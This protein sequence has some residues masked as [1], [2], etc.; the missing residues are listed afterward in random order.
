MPTTGLS[1]FGFYPTDIASQYLTKVCRAED[2]SPEALA[3]TW[4]AARQRLGAAQIKAGSPEVK[5]VPQECAGHLQALMAHPLMARFQADFAGQCQVKMVE[6]RPLL[7]VQTHVE[8]KRCSGLHDAKGAKPLQLMERCLPLGGQQFQVT[9]EQDRTGRGLLIRHPDFNLQTFGGTGT[10]TPEGAL[11]VGPVIGVGAPWVHTLEL[12]GR[13]Y[14]RNGYHRAVGLMEAGH[15]HM[16]CLML[17]GHRSQL[18]VD[19]F[20][21]DIMQSEN[22][23]TLGHFDEAR[24]TEVQLRK[25]TKVISISWTEFLVPEQD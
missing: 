22:A 24:A 19:G 17:K 3:A 1:I 18:S 21:D 13:V 9:W 16:P 5:E 20:A 10:T 11:V 4:Q 2:A 15:T 14:L 6:I 12:D 7:A 23:P 8:R 25:G